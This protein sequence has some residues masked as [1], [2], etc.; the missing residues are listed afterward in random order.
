MGKIYKA[1]KRAN[2]KAEGRFIDDKG[3]GAGQFDTSYKLILT[4]SD[5]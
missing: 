1:T 3:K 4:H 2:N 5:F